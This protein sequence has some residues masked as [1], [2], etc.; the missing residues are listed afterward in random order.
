MLEFFEI[1]C[2]I[3][4]HGYVDLSS[5]VGSIKRDA[6]VSSS[7]PFCCHSVILLNGVL[8]VCYMF[9]AHVFY[10][11]IV[12]NEREL[13]WSPIVCP[14]PGDQFALLVASLN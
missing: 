7:V 9:F 2:D 10:S 3:V 11:K 8:K 14:K 4:W 13:D 1:F 6:N 5:L 12:Y